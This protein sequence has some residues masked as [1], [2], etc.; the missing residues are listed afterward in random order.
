MKRVGI[1]LITVTLVAGM[2]S[3]VQPVPFYDLTATSTAGGSIAMPGEGTFMYD[4]GTVVNL[5]AEV[6]EGYK[7]VNWTGD[8]STIKDLTATQTTIITDGSYSITANFERKYRPMVAGG[9]FHTVGL[10]ADGTVV[11]VRYNG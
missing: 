3:C 7:F 6:E 4:Q 9:A 5:V 2:V 10:K 8:V 1:L 11:A